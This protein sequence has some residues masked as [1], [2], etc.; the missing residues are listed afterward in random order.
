[1]AKQYFRGN[2]DPCIMT[3]KFTLSVK[4]FYSSAPN[5]YTKVLCHNTTMELVFLPKFPNYF[6]GE[7]NNNN[8]GLKGIEDNQTIFPPNAP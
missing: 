1:M 5:S 8:T 6:Q 3:L 7:K 2:A 4:N